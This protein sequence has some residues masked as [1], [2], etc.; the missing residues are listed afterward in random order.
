MTISAK[1][2][3]DYLN[4]I[5]SA[6]EQIENYVQDVDEVAFLR[7]KMMQDAVLRNFEIIG[8]ASHNIIIKHPQ[9]TSTYPKLPLAFAY[10]MRNAIAHGYFKVDLEIVWK[11]I[12][13]NLPELY[14]KIKHIIK[15]LPQT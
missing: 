3:C 8:E 2:L 1:R 12:E 7:N 14:E 4:H 9:F 15:D 6:I 11:T 13:N 10:Q 5:L